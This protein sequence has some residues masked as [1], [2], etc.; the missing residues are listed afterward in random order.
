MGKSSRTVEKEIPEE[1]MQANREALL[2]AS[3]VAQMGYIP[4]YGAQ[5]AALTDAQKAAMNNTYG[6][7]GSFGLAAPA[8][9]NFGMPEVVNTGG[10]DGYATSPIFDAAMAEFQGARPAQYDYLNSFFIDPV[11]GE[12]GSRGMGVDQSYYNMMMEKL[13]KEAEGSTKKKKKKKD[14]GGT[15]TTSSNFTGDEHT[16]G[17]FRE[18]GDN[19]YGS[20]EDHDANFSYSFNNPMSGIM[21]YFKK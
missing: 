18:F 19:T 7:A 11:T 21:D 14:K 6:A 2:D 12:V 5:V 16:A 17:W 20:H 8:R 3:N 15:S 13:Q 10:I 1:I 4:K 9:N